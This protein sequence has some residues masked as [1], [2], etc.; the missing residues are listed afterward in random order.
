MPISSFS[1]GLQKV[2]ACRP[3][4]YGTSLIR[5]QAMQGT[6]NEF[7]ASS[8]PAEEIEKIKDSLDCNLYFFGNNVSH[9]GM[10]LVLII[11]IVVLL[12]VCTN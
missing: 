4:T 11:T 10:Y 5:N 8:V 6:L 9:L 3:G 12:G 7:Q 1:D 2:I